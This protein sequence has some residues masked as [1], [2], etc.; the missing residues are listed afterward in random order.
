VTAAGSLPQR[1][2]SITFTAGVQDEARGL[3]GSLTPG[4]ASQPIFG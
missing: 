4:P 1:L 3:F 2:S